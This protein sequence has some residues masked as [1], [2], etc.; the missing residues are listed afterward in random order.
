M[1][2]NVNEIN[3]IYKMSYNTSLSRGKKRQFLMNETIISCLKQEEEYVNCKFI[4]EESLKSLWGKSK[5]FKVDIAIYDE[6]NLKEISLLK[7]PASNVHQN[8]INFLNS[9]NSD[10]DRLSYYKDNIKFKII[11]I[12]RIIVIIQ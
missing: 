9:I 8:H 11:N 3:E 5:T 1:E 12:K 10:I 7:A 2:I 6:N 4:Q